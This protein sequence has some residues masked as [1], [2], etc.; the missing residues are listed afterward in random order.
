M[1]ST[2]LVLT[3]FLTKKII[4]RGENCI[5]PRYA[6]NTPNFGT[7]CMDPYTVIKGIFQATN[8]YFVPR[9]I[10]ESM[11]SYKQNMLV[12]KLLSITVVLKFPL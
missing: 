5:S 11:Q 1:M 10:L 8:L 9:K 3:Q 12:A 2:F 6:S 4:D 7:N